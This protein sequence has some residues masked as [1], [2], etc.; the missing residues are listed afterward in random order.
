MPS[1]PSIDTSQLR[2]QDA[3]HNKKA[4]LAP[5]TT[6]AQNSSQNQ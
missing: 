2:R 6:K 3:A 4:T 5:T 1:D